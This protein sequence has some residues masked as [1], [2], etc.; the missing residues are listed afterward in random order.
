MNASRKGEGRGVDGGWWMVDLLQK[1][2]NA[3]PAG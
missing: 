1:R 2:E 3:M